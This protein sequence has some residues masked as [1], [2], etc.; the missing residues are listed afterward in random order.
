MFRKA[1][2]TESR[3]PRAPRR[4]PMTNYYRAAKESAPSPFR[5]RQPKTSRRTVFYNAAD[6]ILLVLLMSALVYSLVLKSN[7]QIR[8]DNSA[9]HSTAAYRA[10]I[11]PLFGGLKNSNKLTFD[12]ASVVRGIQQKFPE[13]R[14]A[15][16]ELPFFSEKPVVWMDISRPAFTLV[17][18]QGSYLI[19]EQGVAVGTAKSLPQI[20]TNIAV[21]DQTGFQ[22]KLGRQILSSYGVALVNTVIAQSRQAKVP[23]SSLVLPARAQELD[24]K[25]ADQPYFVKFYL[26]GDA[27]NQIGQFMAARHQFAQ[28]GKQPGQY[29]DVRVPGK[30]FYK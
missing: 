21:Q 13:V 10:Q 19:D 1:P 30:I 16:V 23:I 6:L 2:V 8:S 5:R 14:G 3:R 24:L 18:Q 15:R 26:G 17:N 25:T 11:A 7:P 4:Q 22:V 20:K 27:L 29:L 9:Y 28:S 12:E